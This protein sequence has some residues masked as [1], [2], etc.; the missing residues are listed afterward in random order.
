MLPELKELY[1]A[2]YKA[3]NDCLPIA[4]QETREGRVTEQRIE[5]IEDLLLQVQGCTNLATE[6]GKNAEG[7]VHEQHFTT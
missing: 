7:D 6:I 3:F 5:D 2:E 4:I 1:E